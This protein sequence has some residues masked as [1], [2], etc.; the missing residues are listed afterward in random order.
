M[1]NKG[2]SDVTGNG[3]DEAPYLT[4]TKGL[5]VAGALAGLSIGQLALVLVGP[6]TYSENVQ[7]PPFV[8][9]GATDPGISVNLGTGVGNSFSLSPAWVGNAAGPFAAIAGI[10]VTNPST[11]DFTGVASFPSFVVGVNTSFGAPMTITG[12]PAQGGNVTFE[13][14]AGL[15]TIAASGVSLFFSDGTCVGLTLA[16]TAAQ[17]ATLTAI[18]NQITT[19]H[20]D[21]SG[22][23]NATA[24][25]VDSTVEFLTLTD[26]GG[27]V[28]SYTANTNGVPPSITLLGGA[29]YPVRA[30]GPNA[31]LASANVGDVVTTELVAGFKVAV[32]ASG[33]AGSY[34]PGAPGNWV[35]PA[36]TTLQQALDRIAANVGNAHPIP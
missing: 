4:V 1:V 11:I 26:G 25:L 32:W 35:G 21:A 29:A 33:G 36:P 34:T 14:G 10:F 8:V 24:N 9:L 2:G 28:T 23:M 22:G 17:P 19:L 13:A 31:L 27:G 6:G 15:D 16:S 18:T 20:L 30:T 3:T 12:D 5:A 7:I